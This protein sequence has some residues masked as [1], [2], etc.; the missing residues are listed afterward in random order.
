MWH[1]LV[2][3]FEGRKTIFTARLYTVA[4]LIMAVKDTL[5]AYNIDFSPYL[6]VSIGTTSPYWPFVLVGTGVTFELLRWVT[7][8]PCGG[9][10]NDY[11]KE[12]PR[13]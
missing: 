12:L 8:A 2:A 10:S 9:V 13:T 3:W 1:K 7:R 6:P 5:D 4:G 11:D